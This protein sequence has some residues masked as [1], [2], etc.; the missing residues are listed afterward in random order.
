M[1]KNFIRIITKLDIKN[2]LLIKGINLEGLRVLGNPLD[3]ANYYFKNGAD[4]ICYLDNVATL[5]GTNN[6]SSFVTNTAKNIFIPLSVGGGIK[7]LNDIEV[8]LKAGADKVCI[9]SAA[10]ENVDIIK[11]AAK[12]FGSSTIVSVIE[13]VKINEKYFISKSNGRDLID[14]HPLDWAKKVENAGAGEI[15]LTSVNHEGLQLGF[16]VFMA[17]IISNSVK[18][19]VIAHGGA[20][21]FNH[22][23]EVISKTNISGVAIASLFHYDIFNLFKFQNKNTGNINFLEKNKKKKSLHLLKKIKLFLKSRNINVRL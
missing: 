7:N 2:G 15:L 10:I 8:M 6:I 18:I 5:Y 14:A 17:R 3:F 23:Y 9:N 4:E 1:N 13:T 11:N 22:I 20:G 19:P 12:I 21:N 16:D